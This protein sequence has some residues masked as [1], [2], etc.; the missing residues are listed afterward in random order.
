MGICR[1]L[2]VGALCAVFS[3]SPVIAG[4]NANMAQLVPEVWKH[5]IVEATCQELQDCCGIHLNCGD[6]YQRKPD[7][8]P[9]PLPGAGLMLAAACGLLWRMR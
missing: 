1:L 9:V 6:W 4:D 2:L 5:T 3:P 8:A 7:A